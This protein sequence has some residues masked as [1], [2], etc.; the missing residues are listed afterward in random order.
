MTSKL[1]SDPRI[2]PRIKKFFAGMTSAPKSDV[3]SREALLA[4]EHSP[5]GRAAYARQVAL[6]DTM[7]SEAIAPSTGLTV[8]TLSFTSAP[9][10]N[11]VRIQYIR[12]DG[13]AVLPCIYYIHGGRM[14]FSSCYE[15]NYKTW[16]RMIAARGLAVAMVDF[17]N[18]VHADSAAEIGPFP[19]GLNDCISGLEWV[20]ANAASLGIDPTRI[21]VAGE[22]GGGN[23]SLAVGMKLKQTGQ[24]GLIKGI[25]ALC[26]YIAGQWPQARYPSSIENEGIVFHFGDN[27]ATVAYGIEAFD[28]RNSLAWPAFATS[29]DVAGLPPVVISVNECD[30]LRD[31]GIA[32]YRL[33][34]GAGVAARCRQVMGACHGIEILPVVCPD[35]ARS[36]AA[37]IADF[38]TA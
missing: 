31:E 16:G 30:A 37:D 3:S 33:L 14:Q 18:S 9:D 21:V 28:A 19:A 4:Q 20:H 11:T 7:D 8:R 26:P 10:G 29:E 34:L 32:F 25:Y 17:R 27:R 6:F 38:A 2:D 24:L 35:I 36:T 12:P 15:G 5:E 23:L 22:S 1:E 13:D